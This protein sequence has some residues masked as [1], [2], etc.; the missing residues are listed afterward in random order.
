MLY[1][2]SKSGLISMI[3]FLSLVV[4]NYHNISETSL[5]YSTTIKGKLKP[6]DTATPSR[7]SGYNFR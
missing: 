6:T 1:F 4:I 3:P 7:L 5:V 2:E